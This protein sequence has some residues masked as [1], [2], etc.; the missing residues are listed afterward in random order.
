MGEAIFC[1]SKA[2]EE[3][4]EKMK[5]KNIFLLNFSTQFFYCIVIP[6]LWMKVCVVIVTRTHAH[7]VIILVGRH[8]EM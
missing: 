8:V 5:K 1:V 2:E 3:K 4:S 7:V 6:G